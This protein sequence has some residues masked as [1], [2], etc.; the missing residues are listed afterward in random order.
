MQDRATNETIQ[1]ITDED[2]IGKQ[3]FKI[4]NYTNLAYFGNLLFKGII[5]LEKAKEQEEQISSIIK[6]LEKKTDPN[7]PGCPLG[8]ENIDDINDLIKNA[9]GIIKTRGDII[10]AYKK[11]R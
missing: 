10:K 8:K 11:S 3:K 7:K 4:D 1:N 9:K 2:K 5:S 6:E